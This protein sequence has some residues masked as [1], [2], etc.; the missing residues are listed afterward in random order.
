MLLDSSK[1]LENDIKT[2]VES[3]NT[4]GNDFKIFIPKSVAKNQETN[5]EKGIVIEKV[6]LECGTNFSERSTLK[7]PEKS[8]TVQNQSYSCK[9][10][11]LKFATIIKAKIHQKSHQGEKTYSSN[12][13]E[14]KDYEKKKKPNVTL[15]PSKSLQ[16]DFKTFELP[17]NHG[18]NFLSASQSFVKNQE[19]YHSEDLIIE[20]VTNECKYCGKKFLER[21]VLEI[22]ER[23][24]NSYLDV[25][26]DFQS[27]GCFYCDKKFAN[28][29][30]VENHEKLH[31][32]EKMYSDDVSNSHGLKEY[33]KKEKLGVVLG[34]IFQ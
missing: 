18:N 2:P 21:S 14:L 4:D 19:I 33:E 5:N 10:C 34:S 6:T 17:K 22:H 28:K 1:Y 11:D 30:Q 32:G 23:S 31:A 9:Y 13:H 12:S 29:I 3:P 8:H 7:V 15:D 25:I 24:H 16:N 27:F 26:L 20:K